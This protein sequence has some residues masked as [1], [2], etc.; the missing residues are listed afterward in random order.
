MG[1]FGDIANDIGAAKSAWRSAKGYAAGLDMARDWEKQLG[2]NRDYMDPFGD[3]RRKQAG[4]QYWQAMNDPSAIQTTGQYQFVREEA[5]QAAMRQGASS[6]F[7]SNMGSS[8]NVAAALADRASGL[9]SKEYTSIMDR[10]Q[11]LSGANAS[12]GQQAGM[13]YAGALGQAKEAQI[14]MKVGKENMYGKMHHSAEMAQGKAGDMIASFAMSDARLKSNIKRVGKNG[15]L[16]VYQWTWNERAEEAF[17]LSGEDKGY[18]AQEVKRV[19]PEAVTAIKGY[20]A[21]D[22][23]YLD[24]IGQGELIC[25]S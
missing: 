6:G 2:E 16:N 25:Q 8:G 9:A 20:L 10:L 1:M 5:L 21:I 3:E 22:Y 15:P 4:D 12:Y 7:G 17:G 14:A 13:T 18:L 23:G 19:L 11:N 24:D